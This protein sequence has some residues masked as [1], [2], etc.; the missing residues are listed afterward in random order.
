MQKDY[1]ILDI[2]GGHHSIHG[3]IAII[4]ANPL[5]ETK[6]GSRVLSRS[7][8]SHYCEETE[9]FIIPNNLILINTIISEIKDNRGVWG[10]DLSNFQDETM[11]DE[12]NGRRSKIHMFKGF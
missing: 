8:I 1:F 7:Y 9:T 12:T 6:I 11:F 10:A 2:K 3:E 5:M 4:K